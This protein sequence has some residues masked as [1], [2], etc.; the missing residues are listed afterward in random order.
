MLIKEEMYHWLLLY[1]PKNQTTLLLK[2][3]DGF[4]MS[5]KKHYDLNL[6]Q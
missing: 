3:N 5:V 2:S 6:I 1:E 4:E